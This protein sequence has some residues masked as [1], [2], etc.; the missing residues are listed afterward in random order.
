VVKTSRRG[1]IPLLEDEDEAR[2]VV[3]SSVPFII[4]NSVPAL[5]L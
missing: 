1:G 5:Y 3:L 2:A 4:R